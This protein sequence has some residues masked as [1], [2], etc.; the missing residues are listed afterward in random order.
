V[1]HDWFDRRNA[2]TLYRPVTQAIGD[3]LMYAVRT[4]AA[5]LSVL[6]DVRRALA[7]VDPTQPIFDIMPMRQ[8]LSEKT[9]GLQFVAGVMGTFAILA[10]VLAMLG[11]YAVMSYLV[12][13][14]VREIG[15]RMALG[16]TTSDVTRLAL[17]QAA[18]LTALGLAIGVAAA[19]ALGRLMEAGL[20]GV[21]SSDFV[22]PF[23]IALVLGVTGLASSYL[24][25]RRGRR[26][27]SDDRAPQ[28]VTQRTPAHPEP[29]D[30]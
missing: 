30:G 20:L 5:P 3:R 29:V 2:P 1:I 17:A 22:T 14:R 25:A 24:P 8:A 28:R 16:A 10:L 6:P 18:R 12:A 11:L 15:V 13:Q 7:Q 21:I 19:I 23:A 4:T 26:R 27:R 9:I